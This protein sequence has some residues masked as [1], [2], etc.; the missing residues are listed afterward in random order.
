MYRPLL[1]SQHVH[2]LVGAL[3]FFDTTISMSL[4]NVCKTCCHFGSWRAST[5]FNSVVNGS[6]YFSLSF[7]YTSLKALVIL[8]NNWF[9]NGRKP[10]YHVLCNLDLACPFGAPFDESIIYFE[11][12]ILGR[13]VREIQHMPPLSKSELE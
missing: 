10:Q 9:N 6:P 8:I 13:K 2:Q 11:P 1:R 4:E 12:P 3:R 7:A 5:A